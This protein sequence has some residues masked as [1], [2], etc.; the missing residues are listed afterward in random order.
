M[1][2]A[3]SYARCDVSCS[4]DRGFLVC[5][6]GS[7]KSSDRDAHDVTNSLLRRRLTEI[8]QHW[9]KQGRQEGLDELGSHDLAIIDRE[10]SLFHFFLEIVR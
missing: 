8:E 6:I 7:E 9:L 4:S 1:M 3:P 2:C 5:S 10:D